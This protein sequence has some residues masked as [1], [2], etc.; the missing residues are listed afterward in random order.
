MEK[1]I[2]LFEDNGLKLKVPVT[3]E[4]ETV[5]LNRAQMAELF[6]RDVKTIGKHI[7]NARKKCKALAA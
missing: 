2:V 4:Q 7:A 1:E 3:S 5:L 6:A